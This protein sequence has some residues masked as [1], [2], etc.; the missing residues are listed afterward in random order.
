M[1]D[2]DRVASV[3]RFLDKHHTEQPGLAEVAEQVG[4]SS[5]HFH[6]L[7]RSWAGVTPKDF[8]Q[9]LT[10]ARVKQMLR[11]GES[12]LEAALNGGLS[13]PGRLHDLCLNLESATPGE[14]KSGGAQ[15]TLDAGFA[16]S[17]FGT[18]L[19]AIGPHG[20]CHLSFVDVGGRREAW[21]QLKQ[22]W[23]NAHVRRNDS[24]A[25]RMTRRIFVRPRGGHSAPPLRACVQGTD[26]Q[27]RVWR[28]LIQVPP[29]GLV[30]YGGLAAAAGC[31]NAARAVGTAVGHNPLAYL[32]PC[33][34]VI[35]ETGVIGDYRWGR[36]RKQALVAWE[37]A[38]CG[39]AQH[40]SE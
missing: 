11:D 6:R 37:S 9:C 15:W 13:G 21:S 23:P 20:I 3:I 26:F 25:R 8:L 4:L 19:L 40:T 31:P 36:V 38:S 7:F 28:A 2:Y 32:I 39:K 10:L 16:E 22:D 24:A 14:L 27:V 1:N 17:L 18:C 33:H 30:S 5:S 35:R 12:V 34:R 29:G